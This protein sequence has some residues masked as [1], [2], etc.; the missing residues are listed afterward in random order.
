MFFF[1]FLLLFKDNVCAYLFPVC[2][3]YCLWTMPY[4]NN[5]VK[6]NLKG[7]YVGNFYTLYRSWF[8]QSIPKKK[9][10]VVISCPISNTTEMVICAA[11]KLHLHFI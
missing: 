3:L 8:A 2:R 10:I 5:V 11:K 1:L 4:T 6:T 7:F 9:R